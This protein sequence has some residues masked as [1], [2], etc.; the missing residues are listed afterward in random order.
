MEDLQ[1]NAKRKSAVYKTTGT[2]EYIR[3]SKW[4]IDK[5]DLAYGKHLGLTDE[6]IDFILNY[7]IK[8]R[9]GIDDSDEDA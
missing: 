4:I 2:I 6:E 9:M 8:Y 1:K 5:I 7:D 3:K